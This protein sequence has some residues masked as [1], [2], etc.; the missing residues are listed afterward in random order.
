MKETP[1]DASRMAELQRL[2]QD[3]AI[4]IFQQQ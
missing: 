2:S 4:L 1:I 3:T